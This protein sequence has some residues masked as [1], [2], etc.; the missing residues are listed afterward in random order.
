MGLRPSLLFYSAIAGGALDV[1]VFVN[2]MP[3]S[4]KKVSQI[5][6]N[7]RMPRKCPYCR[8][9]SPRF[10]S[11][12]FHQTTRVKMK[13]LSFTL[14]KSSLK[15]HRRG[16]QSPAIGESG[17][18]SLPLLCIGS[19]VMAEQVHHPPLF[20]MVPP[21]VSRVRMG[22]SI[23]ILLKLFDSSPQRRRVVFFLNSSGFRLHPGP[24]P[25]K[26]IFSPRCGS[27]PLIASPISGSG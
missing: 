20:L 7:Q 21:S 4:F 14:D 1:F 10:C 13:L 9:R 16:F 25:M 26:K 3:M 5:Y 23:L 15:F 19:M 8:P 27:F 6:G 24:F 18:F 2:L 17:K 22:I 12:I 11:H